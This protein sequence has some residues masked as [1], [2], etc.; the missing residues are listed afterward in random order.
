MAESEICN[1]LM[2]DPA[3]DSLDFKD[4]YMLRKELQLRE[5]EIGNTPAQLDRQ[6]IHLRGKTKEGYL[7]IK[8]RPN[9]KELRMKYAATVPHFMIY[10]KK[11]IVEYKSYSSV[12]VL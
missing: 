3:Y 11:G 8:S 1:K 5:G 9:W 12:N 6:V 2:Y 7:K 10:F 4:W